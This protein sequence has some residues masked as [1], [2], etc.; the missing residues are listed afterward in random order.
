MYEIW[1]VEE[2]GNRVLV[3]NDVIDGQHAQRLIDAANHGA[4]LSGEKRRYEVVQVDT[5]PG[6]QNKV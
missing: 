2:K 1:L 3:R 5:A 4:Q 6:D